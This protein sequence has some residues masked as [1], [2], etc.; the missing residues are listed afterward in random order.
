MKKFGYLA[1]F[2]TLF[3]LP[4][5]ETWDGLVQDIESVKASAFESTG[6]EIALL[7]SCPETKVVDELGSLNE[8]SDTSNPRVENLISRVDITQIESSCIHN[9]K[10]IA[11]DLKLTFEGELGQKAKLHNNDM[12]FL[13]YPFFVAITAPNDDI[14]AKE[15]F[16]ASMT[17][18]RDENHHT[19]HESLRQ[20]IPIQNLSRAGR[21]KVLIGFQ[22]SRDQLAY[23]RAQITALAEAEA[24]K[25]E[26]EVIDLTQPGRPQEVHIAPA[27]GDPG[28]SGPIDIT[29]PSQE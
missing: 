21:Y 5:C 22:L 15:V 20:I 19:Y 25:S 11:V 29:A 28:E 3:I 6:Q 12:P 13:S 23:N 27:S 8:F 1:V 4:A 14:I 26:T 18:G 10:S 9:E 2:A 7:D 17:Y 16:A 24:A